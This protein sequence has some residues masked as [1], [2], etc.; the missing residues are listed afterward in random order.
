MKEVRP[1]KRYKKVLRMDITFI[2]RK[3]KQNRTKY[4]YN[5]IILYIFGMV[6]SYLDAI[7]SN[8]I[9]VKICI[10]QA[11]KKGL[12]KRQLVSYLPIYD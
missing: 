5:M 11:R 10:I 7:F 4:L 2:L 12:N 8:C 9:S 6:I 1:K 3:K